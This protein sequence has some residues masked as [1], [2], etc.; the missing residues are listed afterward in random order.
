LFKNIRIYADIFVSK[1]LY[2]YGVK[3]HCKSTIQI[4]SFLLITGWFLS[5]C[6]TYK[7]GYWGKLPESA[8]VDYPTPPMVSKTIQ[9]LSFKK[10]QLAA[11]SFLLSDE[12]HEKLKKSDPIPM[13]TFNLL[14][15]NLHDHYQIDTV[16]HQL[17]QQSTDEV[18]RK[19]IHQELLE[20]ALIYKKAFQQNKFIRRTINRGDLAYGIPTNTLIRT[21]QFLWSDKNNRHYLIDKEKDDKKAIHTK[22]G[23]FISKVVDKFHLAQYKTVY[24]L[25]M[26]FGRVAGQFHG[27]IDK[28]TNSMFLKSHL[29]EFD[30]VFLKSI[31]HLTERFIPGY[32]GHVGVCMGND[33]MIEAPRSGVRICSAESFAEGE[34]FLIVRPTGLSETEKQKIRNLLKNQVGKKYDYNFDSQSPDKVVCTEL[35]CL[36]FDFIDWQTRRVAGR[37]TTSPDDLI[38]SLMKRPDFSFELYLHKGQFTYKPD[39]AFIREL[40]LKN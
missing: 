8:D 25:S 16:Y 23:Y 37:I 5:S 24:F 40:L 10:Q 1:S 3:K 35:V 38:R 14:F 29:Q 36:T 18:I 28:K 30:I 7:Y 21:Q 13:H 2:V 17:M 15:G 4:L 33:L 31:S 22:T 32:F 34:I 6:Q 12:M 19:Q 9:Q 27:H 26:I 11:E 39:S 20:S